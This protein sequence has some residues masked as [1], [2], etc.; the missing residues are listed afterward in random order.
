MNL[1]ACLKNALRFG[2]SSMV[3][4]PLCDEWMPRAML[5]HR[6]PAAVSGEPRRSVQEGFDDRRLLARKQ[7]RRRWQAPIPASLQEPSRI[8]DGLAGRR[9]LS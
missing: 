3:L 2:F 5:R 7:T 1:N 9:P 6:V 4:V 8:P